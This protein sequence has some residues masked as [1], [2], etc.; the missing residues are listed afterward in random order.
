MMKTLGIALGA[1]V[2]SAVLFAVITTASPVAALFACLAPLPIM[3][4]GLGFPHPAGIAA[5]LVGGG[6]VGLTLGPVTGLMYS[7]TLALPAW[8]LARLA[9][10]A[11]PAETAAAPAGSGAASVA[12]YPV[13]P[14]LLRLAALATAP[15]LLAGLAV[16]WRYGSYD[17]AA[18]AMAERLSVVLSRDALSGELRSADFVRYAP[19]LIAASGVVMLSVNL[20]L[21]GR[22]V[23]ISDRLPRPWPTLPDAIRLPG[24]AAGLLAVLVAATFL[25]EP[26]GLGAAVLAAA[27]AVVFLFEGLATVHAVT[28]GLS[29]RGAILCAVYLVTAFVFPWPLLALVVLGC[30]DCLVP[31]LRRRAGMAF[32]NPPKRKT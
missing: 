26:F 20:W 3:I 32:T 25:T 15:V 6:T 11:R 4:A 5:A 8:Y 22:A 29:A 18:A 21:A 30:T 10:L 1:G 13:A 14:L 7:L 23:A 24:P 16:I 28:R 12:W 17:A 31:G 9:V 19:V 27:L 2:T